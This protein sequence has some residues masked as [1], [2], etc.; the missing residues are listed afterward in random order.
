M[1]HKQSKQE[2]VGEIPYG[3][4]LSA[5][6][7]TLIPNVEEQEAIGLI[8]TLH[9][10]GMS[11]RSIAAELNHCSVPSKKGGEWIHTAISRILKRRSVAA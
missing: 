7:V 5:N 6:G 2:R 4:D 8:N 10:S 3:Y 11:L 1:R 9:Q